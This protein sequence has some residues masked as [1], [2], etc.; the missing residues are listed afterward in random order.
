MKHA[1]VWIGIA[2]LLVTG[3]SYRDDIMGSRVM[4][5]L[6]PDRPQFL[7]DGSIQLRANEYHQFYVRGE[8]NNAPVRFLV[9]TGAS[10]ISLSQADAIRAGIDVDNLEYSRV[11]STANGRTTG[12]PI[13]LRRLEIGSIVVRDI[14]AHVNKGE[15]QGSLLGMGFLHLLDSYEV[16]GNVMTLVP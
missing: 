6:M 15:M 9:D 11:Y 2:L 14:E 10:D 16:R 5:E 12:A 8:V 4:A 13:R 7:S 3:Y 1:I